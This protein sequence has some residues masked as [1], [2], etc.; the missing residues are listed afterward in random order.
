MAVFELSNK[1]AD[2]FILP[3]IP[4][5]R[6]KAEKIIINLI[7]QNNYNIFLKHYTQVQHIIKTTRYDLSYIHSKIVDL[8]GSNEIKHNQI[9][10]LSDNKRYKLFASLLKTSSI[11]TENLN[12]ILNDRY[13]LIRLLAA[14]NIDLYPNKLEVIKLLL[15]DK[16]G[17]V[18]INTLRKVYENDILKLKIELLD[19][20][21]DKYGYVREKSRSLLKMVGEFNFESMYKN[22]L[23]SSEKTEGAILGLSEVA[24]F[25]DV[26]I[27]EQFYNSDKQKIKI[28]ALYAVYK[29]DKQKAEEKS[30]EFLE[31][32]NFSKLKKISAEI[33]LKEWVDYTRLR[34]IYD[35]GN[36]IS[37]KI[38]LRIFNKKGG[39]SVAGDFIKGLTSDDENIRKLSSNYFDA[40]LTYS[41]NLATK[42]T[43]S[44][45]KYIL[46]CCKIAENKGFNFNGFINHFNIK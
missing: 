2:E 26:S 8:I 1:T 45:I 46:E 25:D 17:L 40:W 31:N 16:S 36:L 7:A 3:F 21:F 6:K 15:K 20:I 44:D 32:S 43:E 42:K 13:Y 39:W 37:Q 23:A 34:K 5:V 22:A 24:E 27:F 19:L 35:N 11:K 41:A 4:V 30:Y 33:I 38:I 14:K 18:K 9:K 10:H 29:H 12:L 28:A